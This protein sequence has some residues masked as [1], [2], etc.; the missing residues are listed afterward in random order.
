MIPRNRIVVSALACLVALGTLLQSG[1]ANAGMRLGGGI[2]YL[3]TLGDIKDAEGFDENA[4]GIMA[5][6]TYDFT[7][8]RVEGDVEYIPDFGGSDEAMWQPQAYVLLGN[9]IYG[10][11]GTGIGYID[12]DW[13]SDPFYA[14]RAGV[15]FVLAGLDLDV[16]ASYRF[17]KDDNLKDFASDDLDTLTFGA[18]IRFGR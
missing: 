11:V 15:D 13:Q 5:S 4:I 7:L 6:A 3:R 14:L 12:G 1:T 16:F 18:L 8:I 17:Q 2:H 9:L 10:G